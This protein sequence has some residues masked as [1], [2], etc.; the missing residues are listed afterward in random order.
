[1]WMQPSMALCSDLL[2]HAGKLGPLIGKPC[3]FLWPRSNKEMDFLFMYPI[4]LLL[5]LKFK[6]IKVLVVASCIN[7]LCI[8]TMDQRTRDRR[9]VNYRISI[10]WCWWDWVS[11]QQHQRC[12]PPQLTTCVFQLHIEVVSSIS[13]CSTWVDKEKRIEKDGKKERKR[14]RKSTTV[15]IAHKCIVCRVFDNEHEQDIT[16]NT[17]SRGPVRKTN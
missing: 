10:D 9:R 5:P 8:S 13:H 14:A 6:L 11:R 4:C 1:M 17:E 16:L 7:E 2:L 3:I 15:D 12:W